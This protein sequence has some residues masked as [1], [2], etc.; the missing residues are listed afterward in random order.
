MC[1]REGVPARTVISTRSLALSPEGHH[2]SK[3]LPS[4]ADNLF[5]LT[6][7][8]C[9]AQY[10]IRDGTQA[11]LPPYVLPEQKP[12]AAAAAHDPE[13]A[14]Q[15]DPSFCERPGPILHEPEETR[16]SE[17]YGSIHDIPP[18]VPF[19]GSQRQLLRSPGPPPG[20]ADSKRSKGRCFLLCLLTNAVR[21]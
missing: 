20:P 3:W 2:S 14:E 1:L 13:T 6:H 4:C 12:N 10:D 9:Q 8:S 15:E 17:N 19:E 18:E 5:I 11:S 21:F 16:P 7:P